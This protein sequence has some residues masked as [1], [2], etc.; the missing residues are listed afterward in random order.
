MGFLASLVALDQEFGMFLHYINNGIRDEC[1]TADIINASL[2]VVYKLS[3]SCLLVIYLWSTSITDYHRLPHN[4][5][6]WL[7][8]CCIYTGLN[9]QSS[10]VL[11]TMTSDL[12]TFIIFFA[13]NHGQME[14]ERILR[15]FH[16][17]ISTQNPVSH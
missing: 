11:I 4:T 7:K 14:L 8:C 17:L 10:A 2:S 15:G 12:Q 9:A 16:F 6:D 5:A 13:G 1:S 3:T